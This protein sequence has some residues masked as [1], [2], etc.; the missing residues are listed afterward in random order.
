V[1]GCGDFLLMVYSP[2]RS[3]KKNANQIRSAAPR[4]RAVFCS[5]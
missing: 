5:K 4:E 2:Q 3:K 1:N